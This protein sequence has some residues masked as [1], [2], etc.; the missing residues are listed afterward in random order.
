MERVDK[1]KAKLKREKRAKDKNS[2]KEITAAPESKEKPKPVSGS[3]PKSSYFF[4]LDSK[5]DDFLKVVEQEQGGKL[6]GLVLSQAV[7]K[8]GAQVWGNLSEEEKQ[9]W[10]E[11]SIAEWKKNGGQEKAKLEGE[12]QRDN[13]LENRDVNEASSGTD[14]IIE[15]KEITFADAEAE[16]LSAME[17]RI[18]QLA[19]SL[20][21]VGRVLDRH[22]ESEYRKLTA[23][24]LASPRLLRDLVPSPLKIMSDEEVVNWMWNDKKGVIHN[25]ISM[26]DQ[27]FPKPLLLQKI[28]TS[29]R[30]SYPLLDN[31]TAF[32]DEIMHPSVDAKKGRN[33]PSSADARA[34]VREA[35]LDIR[36]DINN[37]LAFAEKSHFDAIKEKKNE[38]ARRRDAEKKSKKNSKTKVVKKITEDG[39]DNTVSSNVAL[40][41]D[42]AGDEDAP[43]PSLQYNA[44]SQQDFERKEEIS[45]CVTELSNKAMRIRGGGEHIL[46]SESNPPANAITLDHQNGLSA[47][48][49]GVVPSNEVVSTDAITTDDQNRPVMLPDKVLHNGAVS[50][51]TPAQVMGASHDVPAQMPSSENVDMG[52]GLT[53]LDTAPGITSEDKKSV[54]TPSSPT[55]TTQAGANSKE[56]ATAIPTPKDT[57]HSSEAKDN[58]TKECGIAETDAQSSAITTLA[59]MANLAAAAPPAIE[60]QHTEMNPLSA[61]T[62]SEMNCLSV[63]A[64]LILSPKAG[65]ES[66]KLSVPIA[67]PEQEPK[68]R[69]TTAPMTPEQVTYLKNWLLDPNHILNPYPTDAEKKKI[70]S[71]IGVELSHL[72]RW[73]SRHRKPIISSRAKEPVNMKWTEADSAHWTNFR[74]QRYMLEASADLLLMYASTNTFFLLEPFNRFDSTPIEV[75]ARELGNQVPSH[76]AA[77]NKAVPCNQDTQDHNTLSNPKAAPTELRLKSKDSDKYCSPEDVITEVTVSYSEEYVISQLLQWFNG[78]IGQLQGLPDI[79]GCVMLPPVSGCWD[80]IKNSGESKVSTY[81][82]ATDYST[83]CRLRL[84]AWIDDRTKRGSPWTEDIARYFCKMGT[85]PD[86]TLPLGSPVIDY[87]VTGIEENIQFVSSTLRDKDGK[88]VNSPTRSHSR[89]S[90]SDRLQS[91]VDAGMPAQAVANWVQCENPNCLKWRKLP[92]HVDVDLLPEKFFCKD[93]IW[94]TGKKSCDVPEDKWDMSDAPVK[95]DT[96]DEDFAIGGESSNTHQSLST[97]SMHSPSSPMIIFSLV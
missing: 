5:R 26:I 13:G 50:T 19:Q 73:L 53:K 55:Q 96:V 24:R 31:F 84:A 6:K 9:S 29:T 82:R 81:R 44:K 46:C 59:L 83:K 87:L 75:Y 48:R 88:G 40:S 63:A 23:S 27:H 45:V 86:P 21:R 92:W 65:T 22:R 57:D 35:L 54:I 39:E 68:K 95:F 72:D 71:D 25:F 56:K 64:N 28:L 70:T 4:F 74:R 14:G 93:N 37:F 20:S 17:Q 77:S 78:G 10:K 18:Q 42:S 79:Y 66:Q 91:T 80:E 34:L 12:R 85:S 38:A 89:S 16:G 58:L 67:L 15:Q 7:N 30:A 43:I 8:Y 49:E 36:S 1:Q 2:D 47:L 51:N 3:K 76:L 11:K 90:A 69:K 97:C 41:H 62:N 32:S 60:Q 33:A 94:T 61:S 52:D